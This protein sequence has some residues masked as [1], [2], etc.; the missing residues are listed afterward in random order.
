ML[1]VSLIFFYIRLFYGK[2]S[3]RYYFIY[4]KYVKKSAYRPCYKD[5][6]IAHIEIFLENDENY[7]IHNTSQKISFV[8]FNF[9]CSIKELKKVKGEPYYYT[10]EKIGKADI[11]CIGYNEDSLNTEIKTIYYF[12]NNKLFMGEYVFKS[13][14]SQIE[15]N[16]YKTLEDKYLN[17]PIRNKT[18]FI[19]K[20]YDQ[21]VIIPENTGFELIIKYFCRENKEA[22]KLIKDHYNRYKRNGI[23][24]NKNI[25]TD[26]FDKI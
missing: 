11:I 18:C 24:K 5:S 9:G 15:N 21:S 23:V 3:P 14:P 20:D 8:N 13:V 12:L 6:F 10:I 7:E 1:K 25:D 22:Y 19:I 26:L 2:Y 17:E 4:K 16:I